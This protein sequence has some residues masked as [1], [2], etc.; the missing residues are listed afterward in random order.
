MFCYL[1]IGKYLTKT[2]VGTGNEKDK[3]KRNKYHL[4]LHACTHLFLN[5]PNMSE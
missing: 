4:F 3:N 2:Y 5:K 1:V